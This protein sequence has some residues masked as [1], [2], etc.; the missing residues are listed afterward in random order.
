MVAAN[1]IEHRR[2][3]VTSQRRFGIEPQGSGSTITVAQFFTRGMEASERAACSAKDMSGL[4]SLDALR[5][6]LYRCTALPTETTRGV[7]VL[8]VC[9]RAHRR[10]PVVLIPQRVGQ[11][12]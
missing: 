8:N 2:G 7:A 12:S 4:I 10:S 11:S 3:H 1:E 5:R 9:N 6:T